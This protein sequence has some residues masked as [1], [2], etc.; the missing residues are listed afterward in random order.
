ML[1]SPF[2]AQRSRRIPALRFSESRRSSSSL[3]RRLHTFESV[4]A[5]FPTAGS[6]RRRTPMTCFCDGCLRILGH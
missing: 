5:R 4:S 6:M 2:L 1:R 3:C